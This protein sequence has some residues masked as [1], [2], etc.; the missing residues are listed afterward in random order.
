MART[1]GSSRNNRF[2][3]HNM[4]VAG[5]TQRV[6]ISNVPNAIGVYTKDESNPDIFDVLFTDA[7][8]NALSFKLVVPIS[9]NI[10]MQGEFQGRG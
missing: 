4:Q 7:L 2:L 5:Q 9:G 3:I 1:G 6:I 10:A 8:E